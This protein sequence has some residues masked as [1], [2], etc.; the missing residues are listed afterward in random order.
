MSILKN[1]AVHFTILDETG[2]NYILLFGCNRAECSEKK[3]TS[4]QLESHMRDR[5]DAVKFT[6]SSASVTPKPPPRHQDRR[7]ERRP[8]GDREHQHTQAGGVQSRSG[9]SPASA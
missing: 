6:V 9:E 5:H 3:M 2:P 4:H 7:N 1:N 8:D